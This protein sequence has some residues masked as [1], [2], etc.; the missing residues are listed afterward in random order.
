MI[1]KIKQWF[2]EI[3][4]NI[5]HTKN[6]ILEGFNKPKMTEDKIYISCD[7][8]I[9]VNPGGDAAVG[10]VIEHPDRETL[11]ISKAVR[12]N[13]INQAE[14]DAIYEA[15][16]TLFNL[17]NNTHLM[18]VEI[19]SDSK[20][21]IKQ[22]KG[23]WKCKDEKLERK[24]QAILEL[25][26]QLPARIEFKWFPRNSTPALKLANDMAQTYLGVKNH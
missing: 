5:Q 7:A 19:R 24:R 26:N 18:P 23:E 4:L 12:S 22:L 1:N 13:T 11:K 2:A 8:S 16:T 9:T 3:H 25:V 14:Y 20:L 15:I 10:F 6:I 21:I 17:R